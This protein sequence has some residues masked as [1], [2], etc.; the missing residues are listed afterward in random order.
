M[1]KMPVHPGAVEHPILCSVCRK[2]N[3]SVIL[4]EQFPTAPGVIALRKKGARCDAH[5]DA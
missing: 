1:L 5:Q 4:F 3:A 2:S